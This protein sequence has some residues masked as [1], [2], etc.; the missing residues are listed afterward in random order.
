MDE[1]NRPAVVGDSVNQDDPAHP[2]PQTFAEFHMD[3]FFMLNSSHFSV[4]L[5]ANN[6]IHWRRQVLGLLRGFDLECLINIS[7]I[8]LDDSSPVTRRWGKQD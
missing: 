5:D 6:Y 8:F 7:L 3:G 2:Q 1:D 4:K